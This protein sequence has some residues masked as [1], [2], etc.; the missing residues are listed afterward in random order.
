ME[1]RIYEIPTSAIQIGGKKVKY[2]DFISSM[3]SE[4]CIHALERIAPRIDMEKISS[5]INE[6]PFLSDLQK[7]FYSTMLSERKKRIID[8]ALEKKH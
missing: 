1:Y 8:F 6:T 5:I 4:Y 7:E 3:R 2:F